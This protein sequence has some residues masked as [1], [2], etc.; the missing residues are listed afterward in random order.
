MFPPTSF[1]LWWLIAAMLAGPG[2]ASENRGIVVTEAEPRGAMAQG[3][4]LA[5]DRVLFCQ[6]SGLGWPVRTPFD[7]LECEWELEPRGLVTLRVARED[8][9][10][11]LVIPAGE[12]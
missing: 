9:Q 6:G 3:G 11:E 8:Q 1:A 10:L 4:I 5:G 2:I 12:W 7:L